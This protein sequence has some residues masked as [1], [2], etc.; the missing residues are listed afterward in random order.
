M[1]DL[2]VLNC[3][4]RSVAG[5][6]G[7][8]LW[9]WEKGSALQLLLLLLLLLQTTTCADVGVAADMLA[10]AAGAAETRPCDRE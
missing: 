7:A 5:S 1:M 4:M 6:A 9:S 2:S 8:D 3:T 10:E